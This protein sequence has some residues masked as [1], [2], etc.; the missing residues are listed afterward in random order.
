MYS[1]FNFGSSDYIEIRYM[2]QTLNFHY[3]SHRGLR[4]GPSKGI[5]AGLSVINSVISRFANSKIAGLT[6]AD[7]SIRWN[8]Y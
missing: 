8:C 5:Y 4:K 3:L 1:G 6:I 7:L 2:V